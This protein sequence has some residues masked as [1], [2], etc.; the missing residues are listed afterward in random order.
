MIVTF[1]NVYRESEKEKN[2]Y[3]EFKSLKKISRTILRQRK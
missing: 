2:D 3:E 1:R